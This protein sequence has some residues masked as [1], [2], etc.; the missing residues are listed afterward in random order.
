MHSTEF[1]ALAQWADDCAEVVLAFAPRRNGTISIVVITY[2]EDQQFWTVYPR[3]LPMRHRDGTFMQWSSEE[4]P[5]TYRTGLLA[6]DDFKSR[7][8]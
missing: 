5:L 4:K 2:N 6:F 1:K 3:M 8:L 7:I